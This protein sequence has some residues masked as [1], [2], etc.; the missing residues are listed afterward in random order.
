M[1]S[2]AGRSAV[3]AQTAAAIAS[4]APSP[5]PSPAPE[6]KA[7]RLHVGIDSYTEAV[8]QQM[9]GPGANGAAE[10]PNF[11]AGGPLAPAV[12]YDLFS[13]SPTTTG[14]AISQDLIIHPTYQL[15]N[16]LDIAASF[17]YGSVGGSG[18]VAGYWGDA[19]MPTINPHLGSRAISI[20]PFFAT[21]NGQD[22]VSGTRV[23]V[24]DGSLALHNGK[25]AFDAGWF[26]LH[27]AVPFVFQ[28][29]PQ[30]N[31][32]FQLSPQL[33]Q[34]IGDGTPSL[35]VFKGVSPLLKLHGY[36][37]WG[38]I[39]AVTVEAT[40]ADLPAPPG[41]MA[42]ESSLS[43]VYQAGQVKIGAEIAHLAT[44]GLV[45]SRVVFGGNATYTLDGAA[46]VPFSSVTGQRMTVEGA[47][48]TL[49]L[50]T[51]DAD[52]RYG[53]SCYSGDGV[54]VAAS[55]C[56]SGNYYYAKFHQG[57]SKFDLALEFVRFEPEYA[58]ALLPYG[59]LENTWSAPFAFPGSWLHQDYQFVDNS[60]VGANRQGIRASTTFLVY[61]V[62]ARIAVA[63]Y[64]QVSPY[65]LTTG[66]EPGFVEPY[67]SP[68]LTTTQG[69]RGT[70]THASLWLGAHPKIFDITLE[71]SDVITNRVAPGGRPQDAISVD[72]P[73]YVFSISRLFG[74]F[75]GG[76]GNARYGVDGSY[77]IVGV[78]NA[79]LA[80]NIVF[81]GLQYRANGNTAYGLQYQIFSV[82]GSPVIP[83]TL[84]PAYHGPQIQFY[85]RLKT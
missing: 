26:D 77:D 53:H 40:N 42:R 7:S 24:L 29:A 20:P 1:L 78:K 14:Q 18:N 35:D 27:Q 33:P 55:S 21:H 30:T 39:D 62:E 38:T 63:R 2:P 43:G 66:N 37:V 19:L 8:N 11:Q 50:A 60:E 83:G 3:L 45:N 10:I 44:S 36:D 22:S 32:P 64:G 79:D 68:Q 69:V 15:T 13:G 6:K 52:F 5:S 81:A 16:A 65:D 41:I 56:T 51:A 34:S 67:L 73:S 72:Y 54:A 59:T 74:R 17:G 46:V 71:L 75:L 49:P 58:P 12:P 70:E 76:I 31:T 23:S 47:S 85:Q 9:V 4:P 28:Q 84:S 82:D 57:F 61:G 80:Q 48:L 25:G